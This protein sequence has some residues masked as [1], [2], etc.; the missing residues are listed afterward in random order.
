[1]K[2]FAH[3]HSFAIASHC[4]LNSARHRPRPAAG[5]F[6]ALVIFGAL[7]LFAQESA[8]TL[9]AGTGQGQP[10]ANRYPEG[11]Q[12]VFSRVS[13]G[14]E[15]ARTLVILSSN[16]D[17]KA[18]ADLQ[19]DLAVMYHLLDRAIE[20]VLSSDR[21]SRRALGVNLVFA[22]D[23]GQMRS[24][25]LEGYGALFLFRANLPLLPTLT[26]TESQKE[27]RQVSSEWE[28]ARQEVFGSGTELGNTS[29]AG[30][31]PYSEERVNRLKSSLLET[32][33]NAA[34]IRNLKADEGVTVCVLG[35]TTAVRKLWRMG[36]SSGAKLGDIPLLSSQWADTP[37]S[38]TILTIRARKSDIDAY[39]KGQMN[40]EEFRKAS[41]LTV[42]EGNTFAGPGTWTFGGIGGFGGA[43]GGLK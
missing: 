8:N 36:T 11:R 42:Y 20:D 12:P 13:G 4:S 33:K 39:A 31:E 15:T 6:V 17:A 1:M 23:S 16:P 38:G 5:S 3:L 34:N 18:Q 26:K 14:P 29:S 22:P 24:E 25:Y 21:G 32:L 35:G 37:Q 9:T 28:E 19:E 27:E 2:P 41:R 30:A 10:A 40:L 43:G 7:S